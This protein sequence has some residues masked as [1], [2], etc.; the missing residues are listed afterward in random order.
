M[1]LQLQP[2]EHQAFFES[3]QAPGPM[4][5]LLGAAA[6]RMAAV[7]ARLGVFDTLAAG[8]LAADDVAARA[9]ADPRGT[10]VLLD[11]LHAHG[12]LRREE[13]DGRAEYANSDT[14]AKWM[15]R[16]G[17]PSFADSIE[18]WDALL[19]TLW[20]TLERSLVEGKPPT[21]WYAWLEQNP[22][23]LRTFQ[24]MLGGMARG[25]APAIAQ[26][27]ALPPTARRLLD[28]GGSHALYAAAFCR[29][30]PELHATVLDF[31]GAVS[32]GRENVAAEGLEDRIGF[33]EADFLNEPLVA[34]GDGGYDAVLLCR[35]VHGLDPEANTS[36]LRKAHDA[37][38]PG[39]RVIVVEE[40][41]PG[42]HSA[43]SV[44]D[45]FM[46]MFSLNMYHLM[47]ARMYTTDEMAGWLAA[48]G[49]DPAGVHEE[50]A[51]ADRVIT[52]ARG[53]EG[54]AS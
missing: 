2:E 11:A 21:D 45:A 22:R 38:A 46:R 12:Y 20:P 41:D 15:V 25:R 16:N 17:G 24:T 26:A 30:L 23:T 1:P 19:F 51:G 48:A 44:N 14:T 47:G 3:H 33:R 31:P 29:A 37:L 32:I 10:L 42:Q 7:A 4:L 35:V 52:A 43:G 36:L 50:P 49:F 53:G 28:V 54:G 27:A 34:E 39:G 18:F 8:P 6:L 40:Y 13:N 9:G 5:D